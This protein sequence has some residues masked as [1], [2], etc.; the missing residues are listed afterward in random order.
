MTSVERDAWL[1]VVPVTKKLLGDTKADNYV[2]YARKV[3]CSY[4]H[5][6]P[7]PIFPSG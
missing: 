4:E 1:S 2:R 6:N 5:Q 7:L 3:K